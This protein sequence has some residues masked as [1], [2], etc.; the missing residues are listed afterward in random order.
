MTEADKIQY[1]ASLKHPDVE[2][3]LDLWFYRP[4]GFR[5][6]LL[7]R[8]LGWTPNQITVA[9]IVLGIGCGLLCYPTDWRLN[10]I[11]MG[12]LVLADIGDSADGQLARLT[13]Q[14]SQL[15]RILDGVAGDVWF[16]TIYVCL[17][18]RLTPEWGSWA[19]LLASAA[20]ACH[21]Q[22]AA[23]ADYYRQFHLLCA[24]GK[25]GSELDDAVAVAKQYADTSF[26][27]DPIQKVFLWFY[28]NY[29]SS[30]ERLT[31][32]LQSLRRALT[33]LPVDESSRL[34]A[35]LRPLSR[36]LMPIANAL[37]FNCRAITL[38]VSLM[39]GQPWLYW[40]A[41]LTLFN[42]LAVFM[43]VSHERMSRRAVRT[44]QL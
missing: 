44:L 36:P 33:L 10:L 1:R 4:M 30:Q 42:A 7:G 20:G 43:L 40:V 17:A 19:W 35:Q 6:A 37:T 24:Q 34:L 9:S 25:A 38:L 3:T 2:E 22:Q 13:Q 11:G 23:M 21:S 28:R 39:L 26:R 29:T 27:A 5:V 12:L 14:Y 16:I 18:L 31:P 32:Q 8:R 41:E 15:G